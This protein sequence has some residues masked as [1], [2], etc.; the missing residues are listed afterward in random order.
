MFSFLQRRCPDSN[1]RQQ[2]YQN[3]SGLS[4]N[5]APT[6]ITELRFCYNKLLCF[7]PTLPLQPLVAM[8]E[9]INFCWG[10]SSISFLSF[11]RYLPKA[12]TETTGNSNS[13]EF[14]IRD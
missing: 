12:S 4:L 1:S 3:N 14:A 10:G 6:N 11:L 2:S 8:G 5:E 7:L 9:A 13:E